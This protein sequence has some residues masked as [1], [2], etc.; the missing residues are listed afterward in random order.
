MI[1]GLEIGL[2][3]FK[4]IEVAKMENLG[5]EK[6]IYKHRLKDIGDVEEIN[7]AVDPATMDL[8]SGP[9]FYTMLSDLRKSYLGS[10]L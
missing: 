7:V 9:V 5:Y 6:W 10:Y 1:S 4:I 8:G 3:G 2:D